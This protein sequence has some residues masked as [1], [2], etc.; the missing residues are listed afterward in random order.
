[1]T[2]KQLL[3]VGVLSALAILAI[4]AIVRAIDAPLDQIGQAVASALQSPPADVDF[5]FHRPW[6]LPRW[7]LII[8]NA[9]GATLLAIMFLG[10]LPLAL[11]ALVVRLLSRARVNRR[12]FIVRVAPY[13]LVFQV[14]SLCLAG[15]IT[16]FALLFGGAQPFSDPWTWYQVATV[17]AGAVAIPIWRQSLQATPFVQNLLSDQR[18]A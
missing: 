5:S 1:M 9:I 11:V 2:D 10:G 13:C 12:R 18:T 6:G 8:D 7:V 17:V 14:S 15:A 4:V 3:A 16:L